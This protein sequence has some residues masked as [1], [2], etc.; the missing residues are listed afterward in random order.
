MASGEDAKRKLRL[1]VDR[2]AGPG[3]LYT[4]ERHFWLD[5]WRTP[6]IEAIEDYGLE[7]RVY[8]PVQVTLLAAMPR[9]PLIALLLGAADP[10]AV[11]DGHLGEALDWI[12]ALG[13]DCRIPIRPDFAESGAAEDLLNQRG[14]RRTASLARFVR[15]ASA[16]GFPE[17]PGIEVDEWTEETEGF[18]DY[19][20][21]GFGLE[22]P[23]NCL[24]EGLPGR[25]GWRCYV[26]VDERE[27]GAG[28]ATML[29][30]PDVAQ[31]GFATA[32]A[33]ARGRGVHMTLL[34]RRILDAAAAGRDL[35]FADTEEPLD[36]PDG[37]SRAT[38]NLL[39][40]GFKQFSVRPVWRPPLPPADEDDEDDDYDEDH[41]FDLED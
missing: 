38:R 30:H 4:Y 14:Y 20:E 8:G 39:R 18:G 7:A 17:P 37:P 24:F 15:D 26:A 36:D 33:S 2:L 21:E 1:A 10:D 35:I 12:E 9:M 6:P 19:F 11:S 29:L 5:F 31:L 13:I 34:R 23:A 40:A 32:K 3:L 27:Y 22:F 28:A 25:R 16:P 41:D